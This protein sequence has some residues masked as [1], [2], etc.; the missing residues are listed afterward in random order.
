[1]V[2]VAVTW[3]RTVRWGSCSCHRG[4]RASNAGVTVGSVSM[5]IGKGCGCAAAAGQLVLSL[6]SWRQRMVGRSSR[7]SWYIYVRVFGPD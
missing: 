4:L 7:V 1:M 3:L 5:R 2:G 6:D